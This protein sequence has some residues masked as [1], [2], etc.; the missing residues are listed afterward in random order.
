MGKEDTEIYL[1]TH[2]WT[3][4]FFTHIHT[5]SASTNAS[6]CTHITEYLQVRALEQMMV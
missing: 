2:V 3:E 4:A 6:T 1:K 5:H